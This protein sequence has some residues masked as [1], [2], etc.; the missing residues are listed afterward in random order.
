MT[1][2]VKNGGLG[3]ADFVANKIIVEPTGIGVYAS[4]A[5]VEPNNDTG[6][7]AQVVVLLLPLHLGR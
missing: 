3:D 1:F 6:G 2:T 7:G 4:T 5:Q